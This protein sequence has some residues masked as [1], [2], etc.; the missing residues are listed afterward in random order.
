[1]VAVPCAM[2]QYVII[3]KILT[4]VGN[5]AN[6]F[7][8]NVEYILCTQRYNIHRHYDSVTR[9]YFLCN[10]SPMCLCMHRERVV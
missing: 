9:L 4:Y 5:E 7:D 2:T 1:M 6:I 8:W 3:W 10:T